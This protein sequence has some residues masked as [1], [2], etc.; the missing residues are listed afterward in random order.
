MKII[1]SLW[2]LPLLKERWGIK[3]Q[4][5]KSF[6]LYKLSFL[7]AKRLGYEVVLHTDDTGYEL[8]KD[9]GYDRIELS[10]NDLAESDKKFWA[11]GK[12]KALELEG[13]GSLHIDGDV[14]LKSGRI[15]EIIEKEY[16]VLTQMVES[17]D[18]FNK[19]YTPQIEF[20]NSV[21]TLIHS[22]VKHAFNC[23]VICF[24]DAELF[25]GYI[26][27]V[28]ELVEIYKNN[29][30]IKDHY[31][32]SFRYQERMLIVEQYSLPVIAQRMGKEVTFIINQ[33]DDLDKVCSDYGFVH[34]PG[35]YK[36]SADFQ[37]LVQQRIKE[38]Q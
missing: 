4:F 33:D 1:H 2:S 28:N 29:P 10:L 19:H 31:L 6:N 36:Y 34:A 5:A 7:Y 8:L 3:E 24:K 27:L 22:P 16:S 14:F 38:I 37:S 23:G 21:S 30:K 20:I 9:V 17:V 35:R 26:K 12:L 15:K 25:S 18:S 32:D 13:L 11:I